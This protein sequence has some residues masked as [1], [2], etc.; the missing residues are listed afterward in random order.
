MLR[1]VGAFAA[2]M[3]TLD[4]PG[5]ELPGHEHD[6]DHPTII[7]EGE[8]EAFGR[9]G[10][11]KQLSRGARIEFPAGVWHGVR[12]KTSNVVFLNLMPTPAPKL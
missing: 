4:N 9:D 7:L 8:A 2:V 1:Q 10:K 11:T 12:A 3:Y 5:D 6:F